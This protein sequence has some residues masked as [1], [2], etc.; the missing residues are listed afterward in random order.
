MAWE[1]DYHH[2]DLDRMLHVTHFTEPGVTTINNSP[3][4]FWLQI[5]IHT[6]ESLALQNIPKTGKLLIQPNGQLH[7][8][9]GQV[10]DVKKKQQDVLAQ[11]NAIHTAGR[12]FARH[13]G[14]DLYK[15]PKRK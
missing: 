5:E 14:A 12:V 3:A 11:L 2:V 6:E 9:E 4:E 1:I 8:S 13:H 7:D 15:G 10:Y